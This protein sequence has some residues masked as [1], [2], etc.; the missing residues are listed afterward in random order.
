MFKRLED[1]YI[2]VIYLFLLSIAEH[3]E[4]EGNESPE[5]EENVSPSL[6]KHLY[7]LSQRCERDSVTDTYIYTQTHTIVWMLANKRKILIC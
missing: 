2:D 1:K 4:T 3:G 6:C 7:A 5:A